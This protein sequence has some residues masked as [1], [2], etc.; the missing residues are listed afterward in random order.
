MRVTV[1]VRPGASRT[2]VGGSHDGALVVRVTARAVEGQATEAVLGAL[3]GAFDVRRRCVTLVS[4]ITS[5]T[6]IVDV[7]GGSTEVLERLLAG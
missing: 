4:G 2:H 5:R 7:E 1:R 3:A 6:K